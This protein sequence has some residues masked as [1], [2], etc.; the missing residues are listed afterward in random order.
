MLART[1]LCGS[2][3]DNCGIWSFQ[4][5]LVDWYTVLRRYFVLYE[6]SW[7]ARWL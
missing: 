2:K 5:I 4:L 7:I 1:V 6:P 3:N